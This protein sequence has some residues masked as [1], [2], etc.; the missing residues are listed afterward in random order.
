MLKEVPPQ[1]TVVTDVITHKK[2]SNVCRL[3]LYK[4]YIG[5]EMSEN[6]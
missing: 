1:H 2:T 3:T 6:I 4:L 5:I